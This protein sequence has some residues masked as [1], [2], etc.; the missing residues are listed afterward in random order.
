MLQIINF[1]QYFYYFDFLFQYKGVNGFY[2]FGGY[3]FN[4]YYR[5][6]YDDYRN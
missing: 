3:S 4:I 5:D 1:R 2:F 6:R